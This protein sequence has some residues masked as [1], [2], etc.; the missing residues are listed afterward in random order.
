VYGYL[1]VEK[2]DEN[3]TA[4]EMLERAHYREDMIKKVAQR[5]IAD[6]LEKERI[7]EREWEK[8]FIITFALYIYRKSKY[9]RLSIYAG[10]W[11]SERLENLRA[12]SLKNE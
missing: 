7:L 10:S 12:I 9:V 6:I 4:W 2:D 11:R 8:V 1:F 3:V 5:E